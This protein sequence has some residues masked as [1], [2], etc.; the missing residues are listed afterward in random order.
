MSGDDTGIVDYSV[1][2]DRSINDGV[3][4]CGDD[5]GID[6]DS[7]NGGGLIDD[8]GL[9]SGYDTEIIDDSVN[10]G[11]SINDGVTVSDN[12]GISGDSVND[13]SMAGSMDSGGDR[14]ELDVYETCS[15]VSGSYDGFT[16]GDIWYRTD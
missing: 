3:L 7:A 2:D 8:G 13:G 14:D 12:T 10:D 9:V 15:Y 5:I 6:G 16:S 1:I 11:G 4:V